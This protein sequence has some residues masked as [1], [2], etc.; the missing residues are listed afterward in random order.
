[1]LRAR[2]EEVGPWERYTLGCKNDLLTIQSQ[3]NGKYVSTELAYPAPFTDL[4]RARATVVGP[5]EMYRDTDQICSDI[6]PI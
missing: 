4:L 1:M 6:N 3:A 5:W 2:S